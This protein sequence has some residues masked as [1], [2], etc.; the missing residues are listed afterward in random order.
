ML[1]IDT[2][3]VIEGHSDRTW[4][5]L[6]W[7]MQHLTRHETW[8]NTCETKIAERWPAWHAWWPSSGS[9]P[10]GSAWMPCSTQP[11]STRRHEFF[12]TFETISTRKN[13]CIVEKTHHFHPFYGL[14]G[15]NGDVV[16]V[17]TSPCPSLILLIFVSMGDDCIA[18]KTRLKKHRLDHRTAKKISIWLWWGRRY[19]GSFKMINGSMIMSSSEQVWPC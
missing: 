15:F 13:G 14:W 18:R 12:Q 3:C 19:H 10:I 2:N 16:F 7:F 11:R 6:S 4:D 5:T 1:L 17:L 9:S 8:P